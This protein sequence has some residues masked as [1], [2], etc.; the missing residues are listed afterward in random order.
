[1]YK[2]PE[3][4]VPIPGYDGV[5]TISDKGIVRKHGE[6]MKPYHN[7]GN[8]CHLKIKLTRNGDRKAFYIHQL[9]ASVFIPNPGML[10][11]VNH[12]DHDPENNSVT[13]LEWVS[14]KDNCVDA[15]GYRAM[16]RRFECPNLELF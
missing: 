1:M 8:D 16:K 3:I 4:I 14:H 13:N 5:Y 12:K 11:E 7:K 6:V 2:I 15:A 9:V 10:P